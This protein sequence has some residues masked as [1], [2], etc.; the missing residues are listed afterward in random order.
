[1]IRYDTVCYA[2]DLFLVAFLLPLS[3]YVFCYSVLCFAS[4][5]FACFFASSDCICWAFDCFGFALLFVVHLFVCFVCFFD[6]DLHIA[7]L[8][9]DS[10]FVTS[11]C[12]VVLSLALIR[13]AFGSHC[14]PRR[15][16]GPTAQRAEV[17]RPE[18]PTGQRA[19]GR[20]HP[21]N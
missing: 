6:F 20:F 14:P 4:L 8:R 12:C 11:L 17:P 15:P 16:N 5:W 21:F 7:L 19:E 18:R 10:L 3:L 2:M 9:F 13:F 1:M